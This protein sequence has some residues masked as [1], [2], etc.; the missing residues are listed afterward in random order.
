MR[1]CSRASSST[2]AR[3]FSR[4]V[5]ASRVASSRFSANASPSSFFCAASRA[6]SVPSRIARLLV[7]ARTTAANRKCTHSTRGGY[8]C[9]TVLARHHIALPSITIASMARARAWRGC[10]MNMPNM[11]TRIMIAIT[12]PR[13]GPV[14]A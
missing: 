4:P 11:I 1:G 13:A 5:S 8:R 3:R 2:I 10:R 14:I 9:G 12:A 7:D 6:R